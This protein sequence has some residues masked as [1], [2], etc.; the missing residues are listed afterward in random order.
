MKEEK[1]CNIIEWTMTVFFS[2]AI[3]IVTFLVTHFVT[4]KIKKE[5]MEKKHSL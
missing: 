1:A 2:I 5:A 3:G 4:E